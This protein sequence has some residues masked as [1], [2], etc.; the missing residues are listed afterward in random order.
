[1]AFCQSVW[2]SKRPE[3]HS[4]IPLYVAALLCLTLQVCCV[5]RDVRCIDTCSA[6]TELGGLGM[7]GYNGELGAMSE[8]TISTALEA[9]R[10]RISRAEQ[11]RAELDR[12][13]SAGKEEQRLLERLLALRR[14]MSPASD[15]GCAVELGR[16]VSS[17]APPVQVGSEA[18]EAVIREL[19]S[20]D[21]PLHISELMRL[22]RE[23]N[24]RIPGAGTQANLITHLRRDQRIVRP[25]RGMYGLSV[26]GLENMR[27]PKRR[28]R[29]R[30][31]V[32]STGSDGRSQA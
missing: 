30:K 17:S 21:R 19:S 15:G 20:A 24:V 1:M 2:T 3:S 11:E 8:E 13:I 6:S 29:L 31:R 5:I 18:I 28:R 10:T 16:E 27:A 14:G 25:T 22:L 7:Q 23:K 26:W 9:A 4:S 32:R 12:V